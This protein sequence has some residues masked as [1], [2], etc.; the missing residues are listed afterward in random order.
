MSYTNPTPPLEP[1]SRWDRLIRRSRKQRRDGVSELTTRRAIERG[2]IEAE[3][4]L[5]NTRVKLVSLHK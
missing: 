2:E 4:L 5:G 1:L 3:K